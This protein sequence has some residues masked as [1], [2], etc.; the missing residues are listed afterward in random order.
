VSGAPHLAPYVASKHALLG[1]TRSAA[2][3]V[4]ARGI[5]VTAVLPGPVE[6]R[7]MDRISDGRTTAGTSATTR[8]TL[9]DGG[10][11]ARIEEVVGAALFLLSEEASFVTG[12][13]LLVDGGRRA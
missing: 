10:R 8:P 1:L 11:R 12:D 7:M 2:Q 4:A 13:G 6:G 9:L 5:R 3:E